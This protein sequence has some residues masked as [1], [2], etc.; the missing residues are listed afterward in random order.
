MNNLPPHIKC[1]APEHQ[2]WILDNG[3]DKRFDYDIGPDDIVFDIGGYTGYFTEN[4]HEKYNCN[5][6]LF[7]PVKEFCSVAMDKFKGN[8]KIECHNFALGNNDG[9]FFISKTGDSS[10]AS[11]S[12]EECFIKSYSEF[13]KRVDKVKLLEM[14]IEGSEYGLLDHMLDCGASNIEN[15][16]I[17]FHKN[18]ENYEERRYKIQ[19]R[20]KETHEINFKYDFIW[21]SWRI[22]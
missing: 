9:S 4:I 10:S 14:N 21:E 18:V 8:D 3:E 11:D 22:K 15:L 5:V 17:Q 19:E 20:L 13:M 12:G 6:H 16:Q 2:R 1:L 7:E